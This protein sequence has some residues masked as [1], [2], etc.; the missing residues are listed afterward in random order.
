MLQLVS[1]L[2][3]LYEVILG[4]GEKYKLFREFLLR[5]V[6]KFDHSIVEILSKFLAPGEIE[7]LRDRGTL[8]SE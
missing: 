3:L 7:S 2:L 4:I 6:Y 8:E 5:F 1:T